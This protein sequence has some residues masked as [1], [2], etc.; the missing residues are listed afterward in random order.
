MPN[1]CTCECLPTLSLGVEDKED[2]SFES[3]EYFQVMAL[4]ILLKHPQLT[5]CIQ[6][7]DEYFIELYHCTMLA[8]LSGCNY[9][10]YPLQKGFE[11]E[12]VL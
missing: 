7:V 2:I 6:W 11:A 1:Y 4:N 3:H 5:I 12:S 10:G 9:L 8:A